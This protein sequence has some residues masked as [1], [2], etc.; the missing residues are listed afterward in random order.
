MG[1]AMKSQSQEETIRKLRGVFC[2]M[3]PPRFIYC[4]LASNFGS[5]FISFL[6]QNNIQCLGSISRRPQSLV[7]YA[8]LNVYGWDL[9]LPAKTEI[10]CDIARCIMRYHAISCDIARFI[11]RYRM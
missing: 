3:T 9:G 4:D 2:V 6:A 10:S 7:S 1:R 5:S 8:D 11:M